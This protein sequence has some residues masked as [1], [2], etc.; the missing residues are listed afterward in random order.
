MAKV[1]TSEPEVHR[2]K[3]RIKPLTKVKEA[4][5]KSPKVT[6]IVATSLAVLMLFGY[7]TYLNIPNMALKVAAVKAG[8]DANMPGFT[9]NGYRFTGPVSYAPG[10]ITIQFESNADEHKYA[11]TERQT[12]W[13]S[14]SLLDNFVKGE[15]ASDFYYFPVY[16]R[17]LTVYIYNGSSATWVNGGIWY[18][19]SGDSQFSSNQLLRIAASL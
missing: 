18:T 11:I 8:F 15:V 3:G 2:H 5:K 13:D 9:P 4:I 19:I 16:D 10:Q 1:G 14:K 12:S 6:T 17:G 7:V